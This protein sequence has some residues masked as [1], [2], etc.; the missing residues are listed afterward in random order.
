MKALSGSAMKIYLI[1]LDRHP[2]RLAHMREQLDG[3]AFERVSAVDGSRRPPTTKGLTRFELA[4]LESHRTA[5]RKFLASAES[6]AC[7]LEDD[8]HVQPGFAALLSGT[9]WVPK[10]AHALKLDTYFQKIRLGERLNVRAQR[11]IARLYSRHE[12]AAAYILSR[13]GATRYL[14]L[15]ESAS[16]PADYAVFPNTPRRLGLNIYQLVPA[17]AIQDHLL[18]DGKA[19]ATAMTKTDGKAAAGRSSLVGK[20]GRESARLASH[21][22]SLGERAYQ[23][24]FLRVETTTVELE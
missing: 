13:E 18:K 24:A 11:E 14:E 7:F 17:I 3:I 15:T 23:K 21:F 19:F 8:L 4:C 22:S 9:E 6:F 12:S 20:L 2:E 10:D 1:N 16:Q 5:W